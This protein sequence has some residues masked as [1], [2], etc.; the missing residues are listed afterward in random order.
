MMIIRQAATHGMD[1]HSDE[2]FCNRREVT[3]IMSD[4]GGKYPQIT[5]FFVGCCFSEPT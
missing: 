4:V 2:S 5:A 1:G 3:E